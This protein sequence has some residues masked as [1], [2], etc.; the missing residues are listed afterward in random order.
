MRNLILVMKCVAAMLLLPLSASA[1]GNF[2]NLNFEMANPVP[3]S[4]GP[5]FV[6]TAS[7]LPYWSVY[8][9]TAQQAAVWQ[10]YISTGAAGV[11]ILTT[12]ISPYG[13][14]I[15][16]IDGNDSVILEASGILPTVSISQT[17]LIP[18]S[19]ESLLFDAQQ[20]GFYT[21]Y[22]LQVLIGNQQVPTIIVG[23]TPNY[24]IYGADLSAWAGQVET[25]TFSAPVNPHALNQW[26]LDDIQFS[27]T[28]IVPEPS[29][30]LLTGIS[31]LVLALR[32][33]IVA[34]RN[35]NGGRQ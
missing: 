19:T 3:A 30:L 8:L 34:A 10:N 6:T 33:R 31:G 18:V 16:P 21:T 4:P 26:E 13:L 28:A 15:S 29:P 17:G 22:P 5:P 7:A 32:L 9:G 25:L 14:T 20:V 1:Q 23:N 35:L 27:Q 11:A 2:F 12:T 24:T